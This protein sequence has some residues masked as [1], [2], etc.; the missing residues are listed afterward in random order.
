MVT[1]MKQMNKSIISHHSR[2]CFFVT[3]AAKISHV[4]GI[5]NAAQFYYNPYGGH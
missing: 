2:L 5:P 1:V 3:G 4:A